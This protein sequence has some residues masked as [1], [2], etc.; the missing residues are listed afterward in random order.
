MLLR[1]IKQHVEN[2]N[3]FSVFVDFVI[4]V[5][6]VYVGIEVA[7]W[8]EQ[9]QED[10]RGLEYMER[11]KADFES[12]LRIIS[13]RLSFWEQ[14]LKHGQRALVH[15][16]KGELVEGSAAQTAL[17]YFQAS[18][19]SPYQT[20]NVTY[21]E[22]VA[23]GDLHL[24]QSSKLRAELADYFVS[25]TGIQ[26][27]YLFNLIPEYREVVRSIFPFDLQEQIWANCH[28]TLPNRSRQQLVDCELR[29]NPSEA[30]TLIEN[31]ASDDKIIRGLRFWTTNLV[32]ASTVL[33]ENRVRIDAMIELVDAEIA[34][35]P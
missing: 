11:L 7:N 4:V 24:I 25:S 5:V 20:V 32:V 13:Y 22:M 30:Q 9:R 2:E 27:R 6:G 21:Q 18:Q 23:A 28:R 29:V 19:V 17:A 8:N 10:Q 14:V 16:E 35:N 15:A 3:W 33:S 26:E 12:D 34:K 1:R 31:L